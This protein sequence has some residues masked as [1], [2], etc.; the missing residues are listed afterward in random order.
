VGGVPALSTALV[1][2]TGVVLVVVTNV[3]YALC[4]V[5]DPRSPLRDPSAVL[6]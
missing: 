4:R 5:H 1:A 3:Y 6:G 2:V